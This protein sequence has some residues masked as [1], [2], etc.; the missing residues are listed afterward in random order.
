MLP[1]LFKLDSRHRLLAFELKAPTISHSD[2][3]LES[4]PVQ[5]WDMPEENQLKNGEKKDKS[6]SKLN[7]TYTEL[8]STL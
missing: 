6:E 1:V 2:I 5:H 8:M 3:I 7:K 4:E